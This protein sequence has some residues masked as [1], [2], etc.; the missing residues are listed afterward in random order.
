[1]LSMVLGKE[2][3]IAGKAARTSNAGEMMAPPGR[4][5]QPLQEL[6]RY[7]NTEASVPSAIEPQRQTLIGRRCPTARFRCCRAA[8]A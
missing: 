8:A 4:R 5:R 2:K 7:G 1:M 3:R 6:G